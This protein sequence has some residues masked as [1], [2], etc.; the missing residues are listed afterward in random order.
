M[1]E[2]T[3][4]GTAVLIVGDAMIDSYKTC[5]MQR[6]SPE[7]PVPVLNVRGQFLRLGGAAN[8]AAGVAAMGSDCVLLALSGQ[9]GHSD[10]LSS[11]LAEA[12][13]ASEV[14]P[15]AGRMT[16]VKE[17]I[18]AMNQQVC[19]IDYE[20]RFV[21]ADSELLMQRAV[22]LLDGCALIAV[23]DY[24]KGVTAA[25]PRLMAETGRRGLRVLVDP[26]RTD[27][28][29]YA[30]AYL[31]KPNWNEFLATA[32]QERLL[33][34][35]LSPQNRS[36]VAEIGAELNRRFGLTHLL[37]TAGADGYLHVGPDGL[38][39]GSTRAREVFDLSGAG[40]S[41][42]AALTAFFA[43]GTPLIRAIEMGNAAAGLAVGH[44]GTTVIRRDEL[45]NEIGE[46]DESTSLAALRRLAAEG[47]RIVFTNGCF[48]ILH[49][50]HLALLRQAK[51]EGDVLVVGVN[52]DASVARLK[53]P[54]RPINPLADR[55]TMLVGLKPVDF[56]LSFDED[57]P[58]ELIAQVSP[59]VL[60]K[61]G[62]YTRDTV[63]GADLVEARGG[64]VVIVATLEGRSTTNVIA[65][66]ANHGSKSGNSG[67]RGQTSPT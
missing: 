43:Q 29:I 37:V 4:S 7:A 54:N 65:R 58:E 42:L 61:G 59:D 14:M 41:F 60:V 55:M 46:S 15:L 35:P 57:T 53:G 63:V 3:P 25:L 49:A 16:I 33:D 10:T 11:M 67:V 62:D 36:R 47:K 23:S 51:T 30:G 45:M 38:S 28:T 66:S 18:L 5:S 12:G 44:V 17:R 24:D 39:H 34:G 50:G 21:E 1:P 6:I 13:V 8:L 48:D 52:S 64:R 22:A 32:R 56:V 27:W 40:D 19:R 20:D 31:L 9:D 26:K 2:T